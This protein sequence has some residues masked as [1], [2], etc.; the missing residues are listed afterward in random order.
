MGMTKSI[1][2]RKLNCAIHGVAHAYPHCVSSE[3]DH[4]AQNE[5]L[6]TK[7]KGENRNAKFNVR[8]PI[9]VSS[10][11]VKASQDIS[12]VAEDKEMTFTMEKICLS[13][14]ISTN[15]KNNQWLNIYY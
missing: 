7:E 6:D 2:K 10:K 5:W 9:W 14:S 4:S 15:C 3:R 13:R 12:K 11:R 8:D 1:N